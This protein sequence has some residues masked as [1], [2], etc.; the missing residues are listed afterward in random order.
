M[1]HSSLIC[2]P[3]Q[4][5]LV[6]VP[7]HISSM[8]VDTAVQPLHI[9]LA[10][11]RKPLYFSFKSPI[12]DYSVDAASTLL[13]HSHRAARPLHGSDDRRSGSEGCLNSVQQPG[14]WSV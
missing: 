4:D 2:W 11:N 9:F 7:A 6:R 10:H 14:A 5:L 12:C 13:M 1:Q 8:L 3:H